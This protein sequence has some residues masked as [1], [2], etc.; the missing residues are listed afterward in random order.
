MVKSICDT[1]EE[2]RYWTYLYV[3]DVLPDITD[4]MEALPF[5]LQAVTI[6]GRGVVEFDLYAIYRNSTYRYLES[7]IDSVVRYIKE[8]IYV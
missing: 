5:L 1:D 4:F 3:N 6:V 2:R 8:Y 7:D